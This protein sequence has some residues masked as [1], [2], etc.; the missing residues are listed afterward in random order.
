MPLIGRS[1]LLGDHRNSVFCGVA[2]GRGPSALSTFCITSSGLLC[3]F[4]SSRQL[5]AW[6]N[7]KVSWGTSARLCT[8]TSPN[9]STSD[10]QTA[11]AS[12]LV[13]SE[14]FLFCGCADGVVRVFSPAHLQYV[15]TLPRPHPLG[16]DLSG[17]HRYRWSKRMVAPTPCP[18]ERPRV[19]RSPPPGAQYPHTLALTFDPSARQLACVYS[20]HSVYVWDVED[21]RSVRKLYSALY[22]SSSVW[23]LE[24]GVSRTSAQPL[25]SDLWLRAQLLFSPQV[26]PDLPDGSPSCLPPSSFLSCSSDGTIRLWDSGPPSGHR[27]HLSHVGGRGC[28]RTQR[29]RSAGAD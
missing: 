5:E 29:A 6:V 1:G 22:H 23:S 21:V 8:C 15:A 4:N 9:G 28:K 10:L 27:N 26:C 18:S 17:E 13:A 16:V 7:L 12:C 11:S 3:L 14:D 25:T 24:V 19:P 2:C 20:D